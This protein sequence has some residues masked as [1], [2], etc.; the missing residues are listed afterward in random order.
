MLAYNQAKMHYSHRAGLKIYHTCGA[1]IVEVKPGPTRA[2]DRVGRSHNLN[3]EAAI[4]DLVEYCAVLGHTGYGGEWDLMIY[5]ITIGRHVS[6]HRCHPL[7][8]G[9]ILI[10]SLQRYNGLHNDCSE[11]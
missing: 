2:Q 4:N 6:G 11:C 8:D 5:R 3:I 7:R 9:Y 1:A 10:K